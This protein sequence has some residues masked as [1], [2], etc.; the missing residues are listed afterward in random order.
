MVRCCLRAV[1]E[2]SAVRDVSRFRNRHASSIRGR[3]KASFEG[4][5]E[6]KGFLRDQTP[7]L[8]LNVCSS[9]FSKTVIF[10]S[11]SGSDGGSGQN[12][13]LGYPPRRQLE[14]APLQGLA[15]LDPGLSAQLLP[16]GPCTVYSQ[17][18]L[19][20]FSQSHLDDF[21]QSLS[22]SNVS[23]SNVQLTERL[24]PLLPLFPTPPLVLHRQIRCATL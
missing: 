8:V 16:V 17:S 2:P 11:G 14:E 3:S 15:I 12:F 21:P 5:R 6:M 10:P 4:N 19:D 23:R 18:H 24:L 7:S 13:G 22:E 9:R 20:D 1:S